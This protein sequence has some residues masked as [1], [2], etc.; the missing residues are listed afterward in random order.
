MKALVILAHP[1]HKS[2]NHAIYHTVINAFQ[3]QKIEVYAHDLYEEA[4]NPVLTEKELGSDASDDP[5]VHQYAKELV[6]SDFLVFI[7]PNWWGQPPAILKGYIDRVV[8][9]PYAYD[10]P[11]EDTGGGLP[12]EKLKAGYGIVFNTSNTEAEREDSY[13]GDPLDKIWEKCIFGFLGI[14]KVHRKMFRI[15]ADSSEIDRNK[16]L[17]EVEEDIIRIA[18]KEKR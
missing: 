8:R 11:E 9:P 5:L 4:F 12:V 15:I 13:F 14:K 3:E 18:G 10:F 2:F 7:H 17:Q 6:E 1:Y 16:W